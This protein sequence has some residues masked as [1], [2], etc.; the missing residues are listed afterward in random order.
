[1]Q[2]EN[3][4]EFVLLSVPLELITEAKLDTNGILQMS[5]EEGRIII[6]NPEDV[7][8]FICDGDCEYCPCSETCDGSGAI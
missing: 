5:T 6:E 2:K 3:I 8:D 4:A 7:G 1:M